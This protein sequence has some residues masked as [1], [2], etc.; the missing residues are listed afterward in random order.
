MAKSKTDLIADARSRADIHAASARGYMAKIENW[1]LLGNATGLALAISGFASAK[2]PPDFQTALL[3]SAWSFAMGV[4]SAFMFQTR[5][6]AIEEA[7][8]KYFVDAAS[9]IEND[10]DLPPKVKSWTPLAS[11]WLGGCILGFAFG[12]MIPLIEITA[13]LVAGDRLPV[14]P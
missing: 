14:S 4:A 6:G 12:V 1:L 3:L 7:L 13:V 8:E 11:A 9:S 10:T 5:L 2:I